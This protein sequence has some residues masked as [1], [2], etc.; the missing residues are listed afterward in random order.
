MRRSARVAAV[1]C[2]LYGLCVPALGKDESKIRFTP[3][4]TEGSPLRPGSCTPENL[5]KEAWTSRDLGEG[6]NVAAGIVYEPGK[7][8]TVRLL[9]RAYAKLELSPREFRLHAPGGRVFEPGQVRRSNYDVPKEDADGCPRYGEWVSLTFPVRPEQVEQ[10]AIVFPV[11]TVMAKNR[12]LNVRSLDVGPFR[13]ARTDDAGA[14]L[15]APMALSLPSNALPPDNELSSC[16]PKIAL[17]AADKLIAHP[18]AVSEPWLLFR[19]IMVLFRYGRKDEAVFWHYAA[20]IRTRQ[21]FA[22]GDPGDQEKTLVMFVSFFT[23]IVNN[24]GYQDVARFERIL[25]RVLEWD[26]TTRNPFREKERTAEVDQRIE[27]IYADYRRE[28]AR[29]RAEKATLESEARK[30]APRMQW[31]VDGFRCVK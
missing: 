17:A 23:P 9:F 7:P 2:V 21:H 16:D 22:F 27:A 20:Q 28:K 4:P 8:I 13:F 5:G 15:P 30:E 12:G 31:V 1:C 6:A 25:D 11:N 18:R 10:V 3:Y 14:S 19:T 24:Y 26:K 29:L